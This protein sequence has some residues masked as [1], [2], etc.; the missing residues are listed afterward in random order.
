MWLLRF[1]WLDTA[2]LCSSNDQ[3]GKTVDGVTEGDIRTESG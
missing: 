2:E 3:A 1:L